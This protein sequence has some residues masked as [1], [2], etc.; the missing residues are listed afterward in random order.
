[1]KTIKIIVICF[2]I[3]CCILLNLIKWILWLPYMITV[4]PITQKWMHEWEIFMYPYYWIDIL[5]FKIT[6]L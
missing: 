5:K 3:F 1:M 4:F 6:S 2:L